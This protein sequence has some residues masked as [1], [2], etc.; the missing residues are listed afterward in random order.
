VDA[1]NAPEVEDKGGV[2]QPSLLRRPDGAQNSSLAE[3]ARVRQGLIAFPSGRRFW[4]SSLPPERLAPV[5][6]DARTREV[7]GAHPSAA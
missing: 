6:D 2:F 5:P 4:A 1:A 7:V 3:T